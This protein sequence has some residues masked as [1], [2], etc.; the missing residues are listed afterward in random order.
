VPGGTHAAR[1][2]SAGRGHWRSGAHRPGAGGYSP[3][4]VPPSSR[5][6]TDLADDGLDQVEVLCIAEPAREPPGDHLGAGPLLQAPGQQRVQPGISSEH[7]TEP[8]EVLNR[9]ALQE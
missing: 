1:R 2:I 5:P 7:V 6:A 8:G 9:Q 4:K 3:D